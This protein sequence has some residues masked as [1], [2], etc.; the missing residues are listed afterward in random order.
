MSFGT[1]QFPAAFVVASVIN[2]SYKLLKAIQYER[3]LDYQ[4]LF[5]KMSPRSGRKAGPEGA[6]EIEP[7]TNAAFAFLVYKQVL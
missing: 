2:I 1:N 4:P 5:G 7:N 6:A 3:R